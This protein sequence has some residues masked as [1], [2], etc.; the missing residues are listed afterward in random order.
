MSIIAIAGTKAD[1]QI[2][3]QFPPDVNWDKI[4][5]VEIPDN[6]GEFPDTSGYDSKDWMNF[7]SNREDSALLRYIQKCVDAVLDFIT[8]NSDRLSALQF[9]NIKSTVA[10]M[11]TGGDIFA[12]AGFVSYEPMLSSKS[13]NIHVVG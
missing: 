12:L 3:T 5:K 10:G 2:A 1:L 8:K 4:V 13:R 6:H 7:E 9:Q 11:K